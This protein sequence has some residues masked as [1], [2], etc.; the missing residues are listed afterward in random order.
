M[1]GILIT[2]KHEVE[3]GYKK[4]IQAENLALRNTK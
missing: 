1:E 2:Y 4:Q 3:G